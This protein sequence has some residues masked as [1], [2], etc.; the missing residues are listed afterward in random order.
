MIKV[1]P[2]PQ[3][4]ADDGGKTVPAG[5]KVLWMAGLMLA[6]LLVTASAAYLLRTLLLIG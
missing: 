3:G 5:R 1:F 2:E 6:G 4:P